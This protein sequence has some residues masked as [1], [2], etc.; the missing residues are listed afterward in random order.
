MV[1]RIG[2]EPT[3]YVPIVLDWSQAERNKLDS[4]FRQGV[5]LLVGLTWLGQ[6]SLPRV[7]QEVTQ[8]PGED[9]R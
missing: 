1:P 4:S 7:F 2:T 3:Y 8:S 9:R 5:L 6:K